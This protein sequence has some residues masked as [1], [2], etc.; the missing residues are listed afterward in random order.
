MAVAGS[1]F[2]SSLLTVGAHGAGLTNIL[3]AQPR[4]VIFEIVCE[5][6]P[7]TFMNMA[8]KLGLR[9]HAFYGYRVGGQRCDEGISITRNIVEFEA[10]TRA[11]LKIVL[12]DFHRE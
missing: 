3:F 7:V 4:A 9:H 2:H 6:S 12:D 8:H 1:M 5:V 10:K 11:I